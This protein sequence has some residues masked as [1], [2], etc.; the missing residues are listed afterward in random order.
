MNVPKMIHRKK[1]DKKKLYEKPSTFFIDFEGLVGS[2]S[3]LDILI[4]QEPFTN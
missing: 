4:F 2:T 3:P 1:K